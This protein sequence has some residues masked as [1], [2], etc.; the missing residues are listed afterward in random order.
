MVSSKETTPTAYLASL[1]PERREVIAAVRDVVKKRL[2]KGYVE[3]MNWG[4]LAYEVPLSRHPDT[5][6]KQPLMYLALAAQKSNYAFYMTGVSNDKAL[7]DRLAAAY[8][9]AG[10]K[11]DIGKSCLRFQSLDELPLDVIGDIVA[12]T[13]VERRIEVEEARQKKTNAAK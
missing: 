3:T 12:S 9:A 13:T 4:M 7:M 11:L 1:P 2:P 8:K 6:N 5:Y 10:K